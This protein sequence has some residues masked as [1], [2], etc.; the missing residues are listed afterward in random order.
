MGIPFET[1]Q[2][3]LILACFTDVDNHKFPGALD[4]YVS[5]EDVFHKYKP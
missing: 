4:Y 2:L 5:H 1:L 3:Y